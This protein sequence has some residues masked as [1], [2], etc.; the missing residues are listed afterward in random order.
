MDY[1]SWIR[2]STKRQGESGLG[3]EA[4][5][6]YIRYTM[7]CE[8]IK[9]FSDVW[10]GTKLSTAVNLRKAIDLCK[11]KKYTLVIAKAD[12]FRDVRQA[13]EILDE[14]GEDNIIFCDC[15]PPTS[16]MMLTIMFA[17]YEQQAIIGRI[18]TKRGLNSIKDRIKQGGVY[19]SKAGNA[20]THLGNSKG[21]DMSVASLAAG[22]KRSEDRLNDPKYLLAKKV[23]MSMY[24]N[25]EENYTNIATTLNLNGHKTRKGNEWNY[26]SVRRLIKK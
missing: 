3:L 15:P 23:A 10:T 26:F 11:E 24:L 13:L 7:R 1:I 12:R 18:N 9:E 14:L 20:I 8:P 6:A 22:I 4:Q 25:G 16:R 2:V 5:Q 17:V 19:V 21:C